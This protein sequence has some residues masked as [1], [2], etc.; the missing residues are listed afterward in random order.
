M[1]VKVEKM[2]AKGQWEWERKQNRTREVGDEQSGWELEQINEP[3]PTVF[4]ITSSAVVCNYRPT[5]GGH[6]WQTRYHLPTLRCGR[7]CNSTTQLKPTQ[8]TKIITYPLGILQCRPYSHV[9]TLWPEIKVITVIW[10]AWGQSKLRQG[11]LNVSYW[12]FW[13]SYRFQTENSC[14][15]SVTTAITEISTV[16]ILTKCDVT[17]G[18]SSIPTVGTKVI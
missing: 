18:L 2:R 12:V 9:Y 15:I 6:H 11:I 3:R 16:P 17:D 8:F 10:S 7:L 14:K 1:C 4:L 13:F 5:P